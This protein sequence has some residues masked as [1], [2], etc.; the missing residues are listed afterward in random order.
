MFEQRVTP[1]QGS[2]RGL[3]GNPAMDKQLQK[4]GASAD[5]KGKTN[6]ARKGKTDD[7]NDTCG[8]YIF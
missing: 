4:S 6:K 2:T 3:A 7:A 1:K 5:T 8:C